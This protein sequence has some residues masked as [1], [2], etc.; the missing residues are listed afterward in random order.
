M[1]LLSL[2][3]AALAAASGGGA[4]YLF[5]KTIKEGDEYTRAFEAFTAAVL[6]T[7][8]AMAWVAFTAVSSAYG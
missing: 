2:A 8:A 6:L 7:I 5:Y 3:V 1:S 4:A